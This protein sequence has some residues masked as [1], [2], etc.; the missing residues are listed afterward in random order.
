MIVV[1]INY[2]LEGG[3]LPNHWK[4]GMV[5]L[6]TKREPLYCLKNLRPITLLNTVYKLY[7][8]VLTV[9]FQRAMEQQGILKISQDGSRPR[10]QTRQP[11]AKIQQT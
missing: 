1:G 10:H 9:Q 6:L 7:T 8:A 5:C 11:V 2:L 4:G 3:T